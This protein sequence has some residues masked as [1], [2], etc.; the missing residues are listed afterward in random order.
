MLARLFLNWKRKRQL[1]KVTHGH[2]S[3]RAITKYTLDE[4]D[5][6]TININ[7]RS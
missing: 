7:D 3:E 5:L 6:L 4:T 1:E 2:I